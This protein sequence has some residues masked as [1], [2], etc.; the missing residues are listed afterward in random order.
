MSIIMTWLAAATLACAA[1]AACGADTGSA[2]EAVAL[3]RKAA[4]YL[5]TNDRKKALAGL[6]DAK[7]PFVDRDLYIFVLDLKGNNLAVG[8]AAMHKSVGFNLSDMRDID[9]KYFVK[10]MIEVATAKGSGWVDFKFPNFSKNNAIETKSA[11]V[12]KV[13]DLIV[14]C[15][16]FKK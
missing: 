13:D 7:G 4:V 6:D 15:G 3:V 11:Y 8:N 1:T 10:N 5:K 9:G 12:E 2:D 16:A 14:G